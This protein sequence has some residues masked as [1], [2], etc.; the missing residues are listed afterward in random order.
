MA[1][2]ERLPVPGSEQAPE[3]HAP[4][5]VQGSPIRLQPVFAG[6]R[7]STPQAPLQQSEALVQGSNALRQDG[8]KKQALPCGVL[9]QIPEQQSFG[10]LQGLSNLP[11]AEASPP[12]PAAMPPEP[13]ALGLVVLPP[14]LGGDE[15]AP[16][17]PP[18]PPDSS[19]T[20]T[21][22]SGTQPATQV[23]AINPAT[24]ARTDIC[25]SQ[26]CRT[27]KEGDG[28]MNASADATSGVRTELWRLKSLGRQRSL[29]Y[30]AQVENNPAPVTQLP[31]QHC[32]GP[33]QACPS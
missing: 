18:L 10:S 16:L 19:V 21:I 25:T 4:G 20:A 1:W 12:E 13:P 6:Q 33:L 3:Q 8:G 23:E 2:Q 7:P 15:A 29:P 31:L 32:S 28:R 9:P 30:K 17:A 11:Q 22:R 5:A 26:G 24:R 14:P 27:R